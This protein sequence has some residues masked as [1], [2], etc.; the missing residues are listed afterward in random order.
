MTAFFCKEVIPQLHM[1]KLSSTMPCTPSSIFWSPLYLH[2]MWLCGRIILFRVSINVVRAK[3][4]PCS[5]PFHANIHSKVGHMLEKTLQTKQ[6]PNMFLRYRTLHFSSKL[7]EMLWNQNSNG[8]INLLSDLE[9]HSEKLFRYVDACIL[10]YLDFQYLPLENEPR[11]QFLY[12]QV[13]TF[14]IGDFSKSILF[15]ICAPFRKWGFLFPTNCSQIEH[16]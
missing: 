2:V 14:P 8:D 3:P 15:N 1:A 13:V 16:T 10:N 11:N 6:T 5:S 12:F 4:R 7:L 9:T